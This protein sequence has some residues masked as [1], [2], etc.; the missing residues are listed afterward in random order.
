MTKDEKRLQET[1]KRLDRRGVFKRAKA[2]Y[3]KARKELH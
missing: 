1:Y 2:A 3:E